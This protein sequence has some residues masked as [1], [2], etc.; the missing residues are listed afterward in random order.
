MDEI[1]ILIENFTGKLKDAMMREVQAQVGAMIATQPADSVVVS[2]AR[3]P[4]KKATPKP[5]PVCGEMNTARR[6]RHYCAEHR[7]KT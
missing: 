3:K 2:S 6:F 4:Y 1:T 7:I 5:C